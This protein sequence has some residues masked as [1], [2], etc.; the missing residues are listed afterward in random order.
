MSVSRRPF[1][2]IAVLAFLAGPFP[3]MAAETKAAETKAVIELFTSQGCSSCPAA[4]RL[5]GELA[6]DERLLTLSLPVDYWDYLGWRDTLALNIHS[7]RQKVYAETRGDRQVYTPQV[8]I[9]GVAQA[10]GSDQ[11]AIER[12]VAKADVIGRLTVPVSLKRGVGT[13][14]IEVGAAAGAPASVW[15][16][17]VTRSTPVAIAR[18][19]NRGKTVT[20]HNVVRSWTRVGEWTGKPLQVSLPVAALTA[21]DADA[22]VIL[23]QE[24][25]SVEEPGRISGAAMLTL[26]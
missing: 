11:N 18:G 10:I 12:A 16:L 21:T 7:I 6:M 1:H 22:A 17:A 26:H 14:E 3:A 9:N 25:D 24:A 15:L 23:I 5:L 2:L 13:V 8:V 4:D 20:Y 19:E